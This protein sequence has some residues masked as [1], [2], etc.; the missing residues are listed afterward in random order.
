MNRRSLRLDMVVAALLLFSG[1]SSGFGG[2]AG[3]SAQTARRSESRVVDPKA[4]PVLEAMDAAFAHAQSLTANYRSESSGPGGRAPMVETASLRLGR[5]N[6]YQLQLN[7]GR[8]I[9]SNGTT[10]FVIA[11]S[12]CSTSSV[13]PLNDTREIDT[14]NPIYWSFFDLGQWQ[15][16]SAMLGHWVTKWRLADPGLRTVRYVGRDDLAGTPVDVVEWTYTM[17]YNRPNDDPIYTSRLSIG[18][19]HFP[20]RIDTASSS[21]DPYKGRHIV[22]TISDLSVQQ[23]V[24]KADFAFAPPAGANC[25]PFNQEDPYITGQFADLPIGSKAPDFT[26]KTS[27]GETV[28]FYD[29]LRQHKV[30]LM[31]YWGYG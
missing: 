21:T 23:T 15:I 19:D 30:V 6:V 8:R 20:R 22:E 27:R 7:G 14:F 25:R 16:R 11:G 28:H 4:I 17:S 1:F 10:R 31:N 5:P 9:L 24:N 26:L 18:P 2:G 12:S 3:T 13:A 29:F